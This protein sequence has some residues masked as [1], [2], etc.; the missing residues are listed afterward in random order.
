MTS[1]NLYGKHP[2]FEQNTFQRNLAHVNFA[3]ARNSRKRKS[4]VRGYDRRNVGTKQ[5]ILS[6]R[7]ELVSRI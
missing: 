2:T 4:W 1:I 3:N 6:R 7:R 5:K